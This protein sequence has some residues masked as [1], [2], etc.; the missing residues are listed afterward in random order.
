MVWALSTPP[1]SPASSIMLH[2]KVFFQYF[3]CMRSPT[4]NRI[5]KCSSFLQKSFVVSSE[6]SKFL[7]RC[8]CGYAQSIL[9]TE[10]LQVM[11]HQFYCWIFQSPGLM[12]DLWRVSSSNQWR[13]GDIPFRCVLLVFRIV[14][15]LKQMKK[16][17]V[18]NLEKRE[19][20]KILKSGWKTQ[21]SL[22]CWSN[23]WWT[24]ANRDAW[25]VIN[26]RKY[27][28]FRTSFAKNEKGMSIECVFSENGC[29]WTPKSMPLF[30][31]V[32]SFLMPLWNQVTVSTSISWQRMVLPLSFL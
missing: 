9:D 12:P 4:K 7:T 15:S 19:R 31:F 1:S 21:V 2:P 23:Q 22:I 17:V 29:K 20:S 30:L 32:R 11:K 6:C 27:P 26:G 5:E 28:S 3:S 13:G 16:R 25:I 18:W 14:L 8:K 24:K 10:T